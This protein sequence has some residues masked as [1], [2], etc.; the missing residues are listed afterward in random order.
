[1]DSM[2][3]KHFPNLGGGTIEGCRRTE[4]DLEMVP[5]TGRDKQTNKNTEM[6][7]NLLPSFFITSTFSGNE[8]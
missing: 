1:M 2:L 5:K 6:P 7:N 4:L 8:N 3:V